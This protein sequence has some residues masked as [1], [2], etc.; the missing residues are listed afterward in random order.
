MSA[1]DVLLADIGGTHVRFAFTGRD[2]VEPLDTRSTRKYVVADF[3]SPSDAARHYLGSVGANAD[4]AVFAVAGRVEGDEARITNHPWTISS[5]RIR[6]ALGLQSL[7]LVN[8]F[9][10]QAMAVPLLRETDIVAIGGAAWPGVQACDATYAVIGPGTGLGVGA[11]LRR[12]GCDHTLQTEGGHVSFAPGTPEEI[13]ILQSLSQEFGRVSNERLLSGAGL[14]NLHRT[15]AALAGGD[16]APLKPEDITARAHIGDARCLRAIDVFC[17]ILGA[18]AGDLALTLGAWDGVFLTGGLVPQLLPWLVHPGFRQRF[19]H[20]GRFAPAMAF[21]PILAVI[22]PEPGLL[23]AA[24]L[25][26]RLRASIQ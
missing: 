17:A 25:A 21:I 23:G 11:L 10:A 9:A 5:K 15:L 4:E 8:D 19:E 24:S 3:P 18:A 1:S 7:H 26:R 13:A 2:P 12:D 6:D 20:K 16:P 22:H 14:V